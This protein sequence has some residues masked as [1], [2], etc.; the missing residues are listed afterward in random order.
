MEQQGSSRDSIGLATRNG[1]L[2]FQDPRN[3]PPLDPE[4]HCRGSSGQ[5]QLISKTNIE[6]SMEASILGVGFS[7]PLSNTYQQVDT[8]CA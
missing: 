7:I 1:T 5:S 2:P 8:F 3:T 6:V 4:L